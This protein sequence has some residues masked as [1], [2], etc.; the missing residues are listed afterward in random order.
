MNDSSQLLTDFEE[1]QKVFS[2]QGYLLLRN[3]L[4]TK[5]VLKARAKIVEDLG[6]NGFLKA[7]SEVGAHLR[8]TDTSQW[9][10][11]AKM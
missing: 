2:E 11:F 8:S 9:T 10:Q 1:L 7:Q 5:R 4:S 3:F 6:A